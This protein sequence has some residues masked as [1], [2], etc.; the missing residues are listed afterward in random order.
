M[1]NDTEYL[2]TQYTHN[3]KPG[4][5]YNEEKEQREINRNSNRDLPLGVGTSYNCFLY[6][7]INL[8]SMG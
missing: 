6:F 4:K 5:S 7:P 1:K 8:T 3:Y 2:Y